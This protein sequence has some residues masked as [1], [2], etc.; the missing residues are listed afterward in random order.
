[1]ETIKSVRGIPI[2]FPAERWLHIVENHD[3]LAGN[4]DEVLDTV[5]DPEYVIQGYGNALVA[6]KLFAADKY[7]A[8][9]YRELSSDDGFIITAYITGK[10]K[11]EK[12]VIIWRKQRS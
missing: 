6:V 4:Y 11:I 2:R 3:D 8:V 10:I 1:M 9:V 5:E 12:E 7:M